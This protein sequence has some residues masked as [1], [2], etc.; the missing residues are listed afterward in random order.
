MAKKTKAPCLTEDCRKRRAAKEARR[1]SASSSRST[2]TR[3]PLRSYK[4]V[5]ASATA[6]AKAKY[7][8]LYSYD[9]DGWA[10]VDVVRRSDGKTVARGSYFDSAETDWV[11]LDKSMPGM[12]ALGAH[13]VAAQVNDSERSLKGL[14]RR[15]WRR[16]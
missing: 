11:V 14:P 7:K 8:F 16:R 5:A 3:A 1:K 13:K 9:G 15:K 2:S 6:E 4:D 10:G 12:D